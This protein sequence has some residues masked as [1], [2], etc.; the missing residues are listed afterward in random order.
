MESYFG[1]ALYRLQGISKGWH[2][3]TIAQFINWYLHYQVKWYFN[4]IVIIVYQ[5]YGTEPLFKQIYIFITNILLIKSLKILENYLYLKYQLE[6]VS[7]NIY[8]ISSL[9][10]LD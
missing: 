2:T 9:R 8:S 4:D 5:L 3:R 10:E 6:W 7:C 1:V